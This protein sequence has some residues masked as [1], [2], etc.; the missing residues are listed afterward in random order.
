MAKDKYHLV[1]DVEASDVVRDIYKWFLEYN[2]LNE[3]AARLNKKGILSS[4]DYRRRENAKTLKA[5][6]WTHMVV[7]GILTQPIYTGDMVQGK[8]YSYNCK[9]SG[10]IHCWRWAG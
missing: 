6:S 2:N 10:F 5:S 7:K 8:S 9:V 4:S 3:I 1:I